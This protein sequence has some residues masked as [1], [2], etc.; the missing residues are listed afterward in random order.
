V[1]WSLVGFWELDLVFDGVAVTAACDGEGG[2]G[3][4]MFGLLGWME[5]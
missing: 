1:C 5:K 2:G 3:R 4:G